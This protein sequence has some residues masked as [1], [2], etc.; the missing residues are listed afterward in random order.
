MYLCNSFLEIKELNMKRNAYHQLLEWKNESRRKPLIVQGARQVGKTYLIREF[1]K[2]EFKNLVYLNFEKDNK[3]ESI[4]ENSLNPHEIMESISLL[5][6]E[7]INADDTLIFFD[8]IQIA[9]RVLTSLKYFC[10]E[11]SEYF[12]VAAGSLLGV[13]VGKESSFPVGKVS[14]LNMY[15]MSF[16]EYLQA[17]G[18]VLMSEKLLEWETD[19]ALPEI[20]HSKLLWHLKMYLILGGMPEVVHSYIENKDI[21]M[22]RSIQKEILKAYERDFSKYA[23]S[24]QA[25]KISEFW[26]SIPAQLAKENKKFKFSEIRKNVRAAMYEQTMEW[27]KKAGL[28]LITYNLNSPKLPL[29]AYTDYSKFKV[30]F[31]DVGLLAAMLNVSPDTIL[32]DDA[33]FSE[34]KGAFIENYVAQ[35][36]NCMGGSPLLYWSS[37]SDAEVDF[38]LASAKKIFPVEVKSGLN[39]NIKSLRSYEMRFSPE[40]IFRLSPRNLT[41]SGNFCNIPLYGC[42]MLKK[43]MQLS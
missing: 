29:S 27:L 43:Y 7:K 19:D 18:E 8:E 37:G 14:F 21:S 26:N 1:G 31:H 6:G 40:I 38:I 23:N 4:F 10:E 20:I 3:L 32:F 28:V 13:S 33:I 34:F 35:E 12:V 41:K 39:R 30:Y 42:N 36:L 22:A 24:V 25:I 9:P 2:N 15:P 16:T 11:A 5:Y 17:A